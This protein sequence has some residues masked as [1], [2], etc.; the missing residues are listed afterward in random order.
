MV[1]REK[2]YRKNVVRCFYMSWLWVNVN[3]LFAR[4]AQLITAKQPPT[5]SQAVKKKEK[6]KKRKKKQKKAMEISTPMRDASEMPSDAFR[7]D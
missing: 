4:N 7:P 6:T 2:I 1:G 5:K 3:G